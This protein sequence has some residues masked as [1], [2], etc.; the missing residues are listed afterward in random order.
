[1]DGKIRGLHPYH[2]ADLRR[3]ALL[4]R[5]PLA[6][7]HRLAGEQNRRARGIDRFFDTLN[8]IACRVNGVVDDAPAD[9]LV[10][11]TRRYPRPSE[12]GIDLAAGF[13]GGRQPFGWTEM[14]IAQQQLACAER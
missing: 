11:G 9:V 3:Y 10:P 2:R 12:P 6:E 14:H 13:V 8:P 1:M 5:E 4:P 7:H